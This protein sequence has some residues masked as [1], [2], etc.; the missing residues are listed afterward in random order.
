M[1]SLSTPLGE[2]KYIF[3]FYGGNVVTGRIGEWSLQSIVQD[4]MP[5]GSYELQHMI[6]GRSSGQS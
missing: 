1:I 4:I 6:V 5:D 3:K 2:F